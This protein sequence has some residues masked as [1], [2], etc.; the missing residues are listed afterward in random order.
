MKVIEKFI[1][2]DIQYRFIEYYTESEI[3]RFDMKAA[4]DRYLEEPIKN[5][6]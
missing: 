3:D 6:D 5:E 4:V 2:R 1:R